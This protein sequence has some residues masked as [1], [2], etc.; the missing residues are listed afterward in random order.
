VIHGGSALPELHISLNDVGLPSV[1]QALSQLGVSGRLR[2]AD[3][4]F[5][6]EIMLERGHPVA[7]SLGDERGIRAL[8][9][10]LLRLSG[11]QWTF[12]ETS[13]CEAPQFNFAPG[14]LST[15]L[16][17]IEQIRE[18][19]PGI[20]SLASADATAIG[21]NG[22]ADPMLK[23]TAAAPKD[24]PGSRPLSGESS[25]V[26]ICWQVLEALAGAVN[27]GLLDLH[28]ATVVST[29]VGR[30]S[31]APPER[32]QTALPDG[33]AAP[34][35]SLENRAT[36]TPLAGSAS[37]PGAA[38]TT[39][40]KYPSPCPKLGFEDQ[41]TFSYPHPIR[42]HHCFAIEPARS[43]PIPDQQAYCFSDQYPTCPRYHGTVAT[44]ATRPAT[45][46]SA[47][48]AG[49]AVEAEQAAPSRQPRGRGVAEEL[50]SPAGPGTASPAPE[51][52]A[53]FKPAG[54]RGASVASPYLS[55]RRLAG[56]PPPDPGRDEFDDVDVRTLA[57]AR[58]AK[59][60]HDSS[61]LREAV[62]FIARWATP[63]RMSPL[64]QSIGAT[65]RPPGQPQAGTVR[66]MDAVLVLGAVSAGILIIVAFAL[67]SGPDGPERLVADLLRED[68]SSGETVRARDDESLLV[69]ARSPP[70]GS[71]PQS[72]GPHPTAGLDPATSGDAASQAAAAPTTLA[73]APE[74][75]AVVTAS[76]PS[77][78]ATSAAPPTPAGVVAAPPPV[79]VA[80][81]PSPTAMPTAPIPT[82]IPSPVVAVAPAPAATA[83]VASVPTTAGQLR[84]VFVDRFVDNS[85]NWPNRPDSTAWLADGAYRLVA[86][87]P[88]QFVAL[89][90]P[91]A[92]SFRDVEVT[93]TFRKLGGP[94]GGGYGI[95]VRD[96]VSNPR[97]G[98][99]Q[100]GRF[101]V[102]EVGDKGE[103]GIWR[104]EVD[105][106]IDLLPWKASDAAHPG[107]EPNT[108]T[109]RAEGQALTLV[110]NGTEVA[111]VEDVALSEGAVGV[112]VGGDSNEVAL[113]QLL[114]AAPS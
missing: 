90:A 43:V 46:L 39:S 18:A 82:A 1:V 6:G 25:G 99:N 110:V 91:I 36:D 54:H 12:S 106:W 5:V 32:L 113:E 7:A 77:A 72:A 24:A 48:T 57:R 3:Q 112:F 96:Q 107:T 114:V 81:T 104:R 65:D 37:L 67:M 11:G 40:V 78:T 33:A 15:Y 102:L 74:A 61:W 50:L 63:F 58:R 29:M 86:R 101:Y 42:L 84:P 56:S 68:I 62:R 30:A 26:V 59:E 8:G 47:P 35:P 4:S 64:A 71:G 108:L 88:G 16:A 28:A 19:L 9:A 31:V 109:V 95:I 49:E 22:T 13:R 2:V 93:A 44:P 85:K 23:A 94:G 34:R 100:G 103:I 55:P 69:A 75:L 87:Q 27:A 21:R 73:A 53:G 20:N 70:A 97:D 38:R 76:I 105:R 89:R 79:V 14:E 111:R 45:R 66:P 60:A 80:V 17:T 52:P 92:D 41:P 51:T 10:M 83:A 98:V